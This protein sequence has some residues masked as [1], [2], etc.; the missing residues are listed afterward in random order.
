MSHSL[1]I[2]PATT[3]VRHEIAAAVRAHFAVRSTND[4]KVA[5]AIGKSQSWM[6]RR[7][8]GDT[9]FDADDLGAIAELFGISYLELAQMPAGRPNPENP[10]QNSFWTI[11]SVTNIDEWQSA[12]E[13]ADVAEPTVSERIASVDR[14]GLAS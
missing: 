4:S 12:K 13:C 7:T 5:R 10:M 1:D 11:A 2:K 6:S 9:P 8:N 14:I 3:N